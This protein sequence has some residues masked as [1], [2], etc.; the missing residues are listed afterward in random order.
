MAGPVSADCSTSA[1]KG[2]TAVGQVTAGDSAQE[3]PKGHSCCNASKPQSDAGPPPSPD[4][5]HLQSQQRQQ[6]QKSFTRAKFRGSWGLLREA[7]LG[8]RRRSGSFSRRKRAKDRLGPLGSGPMVWPGGQCVVLLELLVLDCWCMRLAGRLHVCVAR[9]GKRGGRRRVSQGCD[10]LAGRRQRCLRPRVECVI[11]LVCCESEREREDRSSGSE[12]EREVSALSTQHQ[13]ASSRQGS[14]GRLV[15]TSEAVEDT[16]MDRDA[17]GPYN[18]LQ[19]A[20][21]SSR[22]P[23][24]HF[25]AASCSMVYH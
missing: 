8:R 19:R 25:R 14:P 1:A 23:N 18:G 11:L 12:V 2:R 6:Q 22:R 21:L 3:K 4:V 24:R 9:S 17:E 10:S 20:D 5:L 13:A 16:M 7:Q 15:P